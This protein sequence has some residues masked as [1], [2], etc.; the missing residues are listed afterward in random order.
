MLHKTTH[1]KNSTSLHYA[2]LRRKWT[3]KHKAVQ[4]DLWEKHKPYLEHLQLESKKALAGSVA[5]LLMMS[6]PVPISLLSQALPPDKPLLKETQAQLQAKLAQEL[7]SILPTE[8]QPLSDD[9][10]AQISAILSTHYGMSV[11]PS[12]E[13]K[14]LNRS[15]GL[16]GAEQHLMRY[17]GDTMGSHF[18]TP[19]ESPPFYSSGMAP[20][21]GAWGYFAYSRESMT[22]TDIMR[23]KYYIAVPTFLSPTWHADVSGHYKFFKYRKMLVVNPENGKGVVADIA[24]AGPAQWTGKH[25]GGSPEV[26]KHLERVDGS[27]KGP[28]L[29]LFIDDPHND[30]P[31]GPVDVQS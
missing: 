25:L 1:K 26:M 27:G 16:I 24:D 22:A 21:R 30:V 2:Y 11:K 20:G 28:V 5:G 29:Y 9:Q 19:E 13:G 18:N 23:E 6:Q 7:L 10:E 8:V 14:R 15:Y 12:L 3:T 17:P 31:L 4:K